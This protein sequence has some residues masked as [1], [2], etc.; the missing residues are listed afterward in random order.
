MPESERRTTLSKAKHSTFWLLATVRHSGHKDQRNKEPYNGKDHQG[1]D[2]RQRPFQHEHDHIEEVHL[3]VF[4]DNGNRLPPWPSQN[5]GRDGLG[6]G[7]VRVLGDCDDPAA[8]WAIHPRA[9][10]LLVN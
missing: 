6:K 8:T 2:G 10:A 1:R 9:F 5:V 7:R 4:Q 3:N